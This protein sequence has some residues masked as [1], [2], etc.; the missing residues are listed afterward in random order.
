MACDFNDNSQ[1]FSNNL[2]LAV[3]QIVSE[4]I[5]EAEQARA[6]RTIRTLAHKRL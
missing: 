5:D 2:M 3:E 6:L 4:P 1:D